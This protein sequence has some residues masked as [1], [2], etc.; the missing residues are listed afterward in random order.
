MTNLG[1]RIRPRTMA[2][3]AGI[4]LTGCLGF[5]VWQAV[6]IPQEAREGPVM[7]QTG[8]E[9]GLRG[10]SQQGQAQ[11]A[12]D[13]RGAH[14]GEQCA[15][16]IVPPGAELQYQQLYQ[17]FGP[18]AY[19]DALRVT[20]WVRAEGVADGTGAYCALQFLDERGQRVGIA[21]STLG[22][23]N[24]RAGWEQLSVEGM[25]PEQTTKGRVD[26]ILHAH[27]TAWFDDVEVTRISQREPW[28]DLGNAERTIAIDTDDVVSPRF[29][30]VGFHVFDHIFPTTPAQADNVIAKRWREL[31]PSFARLNHS[32]QWD[33]AMLDQ[34]AAYL[35]RLQSTGTEVYL[36]TW[37]PRDAP[38]GAERA[39][40]AREV[41]DDLEYLVRG[42]GATN[43]RYYCMTNELSLNQW[44][45]LI[46]D[47]D[48]FK[49]Y[50]QE[51]YRELRAR[52]LDI[53]LLATDA[54]PIERWYSIEWATQHMD[55]ITGIY[56]GHHYINDYDLQDE[57]FYP[58]FL[59][60]LAW[61]AALARGKGKQFVVGEFGA[62]Q[63]GRTING[64][65][66]DRCIYWDTPQEPLV[67]I[68]LAE[69]VIAGLNG[70]VYALCYWTFMDFPDDY[71]PTYINKW[72][73]FKWSG[74]DYSTRAHYYAYGLLTK[75]FRGPARVLRV[76]SADP[77]LRAA[78][79]RHDGAGTYSVA[80][81]N[82]YPGD[83]PVAISLA[84]APAGARFR[85]Y[86][87]D[88]DNVPTH[89]YGDLQGPTGTIALRGEKLEDTL[90]KGTLTVYTTAYD[91]TP[92]RPV[93][94][95]TVGQDEAGHPRLHWRANTE[96][97]LCYYRVYRSDRAALAPTAAAQIG[98][99]IATEFVDEAAPL[100]QAVRYV[101]AAVDQS[102]NASEPR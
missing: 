31:H 56:G 19:G 57:R 91:E 54:S 29:G 20:V 40:Y 10:W 61:G 23:E 95:L 17:E 49:D 92:P 60:R 34:V 4:G 99:T 27:G 73:T 77:Y 97:D 37:D 67:G 11:F 89:P 100:D 50:H 45:S 58:W 7:L 71:S 75:F 102:G 46:S 28:P 101:V 36:T 94:G 63:D 59:S 82:R 15:R 85:K 13:E 68:Q 24:G 69:A 96:P 55:D 78:A 2:A 6:A 76:T 47:L 66:M 42:K 44:G 98:S 8:F 51:L 87:Y 88:P 90:G 14:S 93:R 1:S 35:L 9:D 62:K 74:S 79:L 39:A 22:Q 81:V 18:A 25:A 43:I 12:V 65:K 38:P 72:G 70:G 21:H 83:V 41:V 33:Q 26:L 3:A 30:G 80:V 5:L 86:V 84:G 16:I 53:Q 52:N 48:K 32:R 64:V